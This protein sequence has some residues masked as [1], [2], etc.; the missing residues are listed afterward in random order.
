LR[1]IYA[2]FIRNLGTWKSNSQRR[3]DM[4]GIHHGLG[5][6]A[7]LTAIFLA[8]LAGTVVV[9]ADAQAP[10]SLSKKELKTLSASAVPADQERLAAYYRDRAQRL[11]A[12]AQEF[13]AQADSLA[14]QPA[15]VES[16]QGI[17]CNCTAHYR[18]FA[19]LYAQEARDA[20]A[21]AAQ[22]AQL[23]QEY[24]SKAEHL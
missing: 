24:R 22:H 23:A 14:N 9:R 11:R 6:L 13:S 8:L 12:K 17:S 19:N 15:T 2:L 3:K 18:Y 7:T 21:L 4:T 5:R 16:K 20:E 10:P 1:I